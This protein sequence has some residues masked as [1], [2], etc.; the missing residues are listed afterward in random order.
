M[1]KLNAELKITDLTF[2]DGSCIDTSDSKLVLLVGPNNS[3]K[4]EC[5]RDIAKLAEGPGSSIV[6]KAHL[7]RAM[8]VMARH[9]NPVRAVTKHGRGATGR[10]PNDWRN[11]GL[12][13]KHFAHGVLALAAAGWV[14]R[15]A[16]LSFKQFRLR[17]KR[18]VVKA[19]LAWVG[20]RGKR[21]S[22]KGVII[23]GAFTLAAMTT[24]DVNSADVRCFDQIEFEDTEYGHN[25]ESSWSIWR[26]PITVTQAESYKRATVVYLV[27][28][29]DNARIWPWPD[30]LR[31]DGVYWQNRTV[32][33][34]KPLKRKPP[35]AAYGYEFWN[36]T[37]TGK[38]LIRESALVISPPDTRHRNMVTYKP[39][40][41]TLE[42]LIETEPPKRTHDQ[43]WDVRLVIT[44]GGR[45]ARST[46]RFKEMAERRRGPGAN[47]FQNDWR[48]ALC[49]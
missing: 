27:I 17:V 40:R 10:S 16:G 42:P 46:G 41:S 12:A 44:E 28:P 45:L 36:T 9:P 7:C 30:A 11:L 35:E 49:R 8:L 24:V 18:G 25:Y 22:I 39:R 38:H 32:L 3:G 15:E 43:T 21:N 48:V 23:A 26:K 31:K 6:L 19:R 47:N 4:S 29:A 14:A 1:D 5:L 34:M 33:P 13:A 20:W 2:S 37:H